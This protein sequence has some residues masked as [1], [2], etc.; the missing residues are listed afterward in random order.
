MRSTTQ[1]A[2][3]CGTWSSAR[4]SCGSLPRGRTRSSATRGRQWR[5]SPRG[6]APAAARAAALA[7]IADAAAGGV[8]GEGRPRWRGGYVHLVGIRR[9]A[10]GGSGSGRGGERGSGRGARNRGGSASSDGSASGI[11]TGGGAASTTA[12][13]SRRIEG[14]TEYLCHVLRAMDAVR[15]VEAVVPYHVR[16]PE[17]R[18]LCAHVG[19]EGAVDR[20][21]RLPVQLAHPLRLR[22][23]ARP[24]RVRV[25]VTAAKPLARLIE[26][27]WLVLEALAPLG[28][29]EEDEERAW[30]EREEHARRALDRRVVQVEC[31][32]TEFQDHH[33]QGRRQVREEAWQRILGGRRVERR[34][35]DL[36]VRVRVACVD[37]LQKP[38]HEALERADVRCAPPHE[39]AMHAI[40][41]HAP[42][43]R[44][45]ETAAILSD[46]RTKDANYERRLRLQPLKDG[47]P[48]LRRA[49]LHHR[50]SQSR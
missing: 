8:R 12:R 34:V 7:D 44:L 14:V 5:G 4:M 30:A 39:C 19:L 36:V 45:I 29:G 22:L 6:A 28:H 23:R 38:H 15:R 46:G 35:V 31:H 37:V 20:E 47:L 3:G 42:L 48:R 33:V 24:R 2:G 9:A 26:G 1:S 49:E 21:A 13:L 43:V 10:S 17:A 11:S 50:P 25:D 27:A 40:V 32:R 18:A 41:S 16:E